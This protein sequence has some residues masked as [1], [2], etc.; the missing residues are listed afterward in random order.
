MFDRTIKQ[1]QDYKLDLLEDKR[2]GEAGKIN[3]IID[4]LLTERKNGQIDDL[5]ICREYSVEDIARHISKM[6]LRLM[7]L[8]DNDNYNEAT[9]MLQEARTFLVNIE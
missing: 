1:L 3:T 2:Q 7:E 5:V 6:Q 9:M 8:L 4:T